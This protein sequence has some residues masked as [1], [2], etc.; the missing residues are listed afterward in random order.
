MLIMD[1]TE[2]VRA[3]ERK[4]R[5]HRGASLC[6]RSIC[7]APSPILSPGAAARIGSGG[8]FLYGLLIN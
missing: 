3:E 7:S 2:K 8:A 4:H 6:S 1:K 5:T